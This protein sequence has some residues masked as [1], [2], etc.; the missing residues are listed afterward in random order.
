MS[1]KS[2]NCEKLAVNRPYEAHRP[3]RDNPHRVGPCG[4]AANTVRP[5]KQGCRKYTYQI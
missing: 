1:K 3:H 5:L 2:K 4:S